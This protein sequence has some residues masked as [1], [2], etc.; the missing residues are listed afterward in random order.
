VLRDVVKPNPVL[1][2]VLSAQRQF[3]FLAEQ[4]MIRMGYS[5]TSALIVANR[6]N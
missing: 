4:G 6:R 1:A 3:K 5:E 2:P